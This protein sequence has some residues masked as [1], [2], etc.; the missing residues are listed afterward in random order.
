MQ[1]IIICKSVYS[2]ILMHIF[3]CSKTRKMCD[4]TLEKDSKMLRFVP[5]FFKTQEICE[6]AV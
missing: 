2:T 5:D 4:K 1:H 6:K 3:Y